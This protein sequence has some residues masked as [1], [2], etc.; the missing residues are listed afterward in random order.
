VNYEEER[1]F[2][3]GMNTD[4]AQSAIPNGDVRELWY[5]RLGDASSQ[6]FNIV[7]SKGTTRVLN[8]LITVGNIVGCKEWIESNAIVYLHYVDDSLGK[9]WVY[10]VDTQTHVLAASS[11]EFGFKYDIQVDHMAIVDGNL[12]WCDKYWVD[13]MY[14]NDG[15]RTFNPPMHVN[16]VKALAGDYTSFDYQAVNFVKFPHV[17]GP[18][19]EY[20]TDLFKS[21]NKLRSK[22]FKFRSQYVYWNNE[23]AAWS[24]TSNLPVPKYSGFTDGT[25]WVDS[26]ADNK[27]IITINTGHFSI[28]KINVSVSVNDGLYG[29]FIQIDKDKLGL[30]DNVD[31]TFPYYGEAATL[32]LPLALRNNDRVPIQ[33]NCLEKIPENRIAFV[34]ITEGYNNP[35]NI[36]VTVEPVYREVFVAGKP[37]LISYLGNVGPLPYIS[38]IFN[39]YSENNLGVGTSF[40]TSY[41][42]STLTIPIT[43]IYLSYALT[44]DDMVL[45]NSYPAGIARIDKALKIVAEAFIIQIAL[46]FTD[47]NPYYELGVSG[48]EARIRATTNVPTVDGIL[49]VTNNN[50]AAIPTCK[51]GA[52]HQYYIQYYDEANRDGTALTTPLLDMYVPFPTE[53]TARDFRVSNF[54]N[55]NNIAVINPKFKINNY[56]PNWATHYQILYGDSSG[57]SDFQQVSITETVTDNN[58]YKLSIQN[59]FQLTNIGAT[60]NHQIKVGDKV[61]FVKKRYAMTPTT[62][63]PQPSYCPRYFELEVLKYE[64]TEGR[65]GG[66]AIWVEAFRL[67]D[68]DDAFW[69]GELIEIYTPRPVINVTDNDLFVQSV[70]EIGV[71]GKIERAHTIDRYHASPNNQIGTCIQANTGDTFAHIDGYYT[72]LVDSRFIVSLTGLIRIVTSI[73]YDYV[74]EYTIV[75]FADPILFFESV[76]TPTPCVFDYDQ[77][78]SAGTGLT[79]CVIYSKWGDV[80][81]KNRPMN[82]G[83]TSSITTEKFYNFFVE[84]PHFSDFWASKI[85]GSGRI[86]VVA[87][88]AKQVRKIASAIHGGNFIDNT[89]INNTCAF[90]NIFL[91]G[92]AVNIQEMDEQYG[93]V[94]RAILDGKTLKCIQPRKENSIYIKAAGYS[95]TADGEEAPVAISN[96]VFT[97]WRPSQS[98][99][100]TIHADSVI[101]LP[102]NN[103]AYFD[104]ISGCF[105]ESFENGPMSISDGEYKFQK[106]ATDLAKMCNLYPTNVNTYVDE[107]NKEIGWAFRFET[108]SKRYSYSIVTFDYVRRRWRTRYN[109]PYQK[110]ANI[111]K[112]LVGFDDLNQLHL[113]NKTSN[114]FHNQQGVEKIVFATN[115]QRTLH[116]IF[117]TIG[118]KTNKKWSMISATTE[119]DNSYGSQNTSLS[120]GEFSIKEGYLWASIKRDRNTPN[121]ATA[122]LA[123][124]NGNVMRSHSLMITIYRNVDG[125]CVTQSVKI[126]GQFSETII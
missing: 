38:I 16:L 14:A 8:S 28:R 24:P 53:D 50:T 66:Q 84:D 70:K 6:G 36:D 90:E 58:R 75:N 52:H 112:V 41:E 61:R 91:R 27:I 3:G 20:G 103:I 106:G 98:K 99:Y 65:Y 63:V 47:A 37:A 35:K 2:I 115:D 119:A 79:P 88:S 118:I 67:Q 108:S 11:S 96:Q 9:I 110:F 57:I 51:S 101:L 46:V 25:N 10:Y 78:V 102:T 97:Q 95:V 107:E 48:Q 30:L 23:E 100:G 26:S 19:C 94:T 39:N 15:T 116:K 13:G 86:G 12:Y 56:A 77:T 29:I 55:P 1:I 120:E 85:N 21:D 54:I 82:T 81:A 68:V 126:T 43:R 124:M 40:V 42:A 93:S 17:F 83:Y 64:P 5:C 4:D 69:N 22:L 18:K 60:I 33:S 72:D 7:T 92:E 113:H 49:N 80:W 34:G 62:V 74:G 89:Q 114:F 111:G 117:K 87:P 121:F 122:T 123:R 71:G 125:V 32:H 76:S 59:K 109:Y 104:A 31:Y 105:V 44:I 45:I 73:S